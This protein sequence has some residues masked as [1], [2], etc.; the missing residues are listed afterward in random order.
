[1]GR[2]SCGGGEE[3]AE[4]DGLFFAVCSE[5]DVS[6]EGQCAESR[7]TGGSRFIPVGLVLILGSIQ[8]ELR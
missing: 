7:L 2:D 8:L 3:R 4:P 1:M 5:L 6:I